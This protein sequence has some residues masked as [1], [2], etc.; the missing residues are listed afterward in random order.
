M[1]QIQKFKYIR[2]SKIYIRYRNIL[3]YIFIYLFISSSTLRIVA[4]HFSSCHGCKNTT[5]NKSSSLLLHE[6][7]LKILLSN[8]ECNKKLKSTRVYLGLISSNF[9]RPTLYLLVIISEL[10]THKCLVQVNKY[11]VYITCK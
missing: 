3:T 9:Y 8:F 10:Y 4:S 6:K 7:T 5:K 11:V 2:H 1:Y